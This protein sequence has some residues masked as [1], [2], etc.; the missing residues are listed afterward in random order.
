MPALPHQARAGLAPHDRL[1]LRGERREP[2]SREL[3][4]VH[5]PAQ[6]RSA[7]VH[8]PAGQERAPV[9]QRRARHA[10]GSGDRARPDAAHRDALL[11]HHERGHRRARHHR[12]RHRA[13]RQQRREER[14]RVLGYQTDQHPAQLLVRHGRALQPGTVGH[15]ELR[16]HHAPASSRHRDDRLACRLGGR[17]RKA[18]GRRQHQLERPAARA[19]FAA[20][21]VPGQ[22]CHAQRAGICLPMQMAQRVGQPGQVR[23]ERQRRDVL[24]LAL[25]LPVARL[26]DLLGR[27]CQVK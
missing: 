14:S 23:R 16:A 25:L 27:S 21:R 2:G 12:H 9:P 10:G 17:S 1:Q 15:E 18:Q 26:P 3:P 13:A 19:L 20:A 11:Q 7:R 8:R 5:R 6:R 24:P 4:P 22:R